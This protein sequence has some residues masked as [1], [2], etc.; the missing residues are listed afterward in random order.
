[1]RKN[2]NFWKEKPKPLKGESTLQFINR[3]KLW[4]YY[5]RMKKQKK[6]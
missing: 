3:Y 6:F 2:K 1:M 4:D 5:R